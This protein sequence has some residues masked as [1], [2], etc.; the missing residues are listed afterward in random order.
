MK[1]AVRKWLLRAVLLL[2]LLA[3]PGDD[4]VATPGP[5][6]AVHATPYLT[7]FYGPVYVNG[8]PAP[9]GAVIRAFSPRGALAGCT[10]TTSPGICPYLRVYGEDL[11]ATP[12][13]AGM[14]AGEAVRFTVNGR[15]VTT[16]PSPVIWYDDKGT[17]LVRLDIVGVAFYL[18]LVWR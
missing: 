2:A 4:A 16:T 3:L 8:A 7:H 14:R 15:A 17:H 5:C 13:I 9:V 18:P 12:P 1:R 10:V 11:T 6:A